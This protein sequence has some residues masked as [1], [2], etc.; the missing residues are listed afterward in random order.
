MPSEREIWPFLK[1]AI[2]PKPE[3]S[4]PPKLMCMHND[5][6][7]YLH[8]FFW[9]NSKRLNFL[10]TMDYSP[11]SEREIWLFLKVAIS[12][13]PEKSH[14]PKLVCMHLTSTLLAWI[15]WANSNRLNFLMTMDYSPWSE[16]EIWPFLKVAI[17][18]KP[19]KSRPPKL[20]C[21]HL[22]STP[23]CMNFLS[24]FQTIKFFDDHG[25]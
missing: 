2:S 16:R 14:P 19:E 12:P 6:N 4:H 9:A 20:V 23:T 1:V 25:L 18:P 5:I 13:K 21:M 15:F 3:K 22:T 7:P 8:E 11:C 17:S 24:Q 10:M